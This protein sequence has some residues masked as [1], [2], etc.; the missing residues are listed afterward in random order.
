MK[1]KKEIGP[2]KWAERFL[3]WYC[4]QELLE[5][6]QGDLNEYFYRN[7]K[8]K[9][10]SKARFIYVMDV[11][12]FFR[13]YTIRKPNFINL[14]IHGMMMSSY[15]KTS[16]RSI[17]RNKLFSAINII[18]LAISMTVG[19]LMIGLLSD[20]KQYDTFHEHYDNIY[21]ITS[22]Y[23][24]LDH[25]DNSSYASTSLLAAKSI[26]ESIP[27]IDEVAILSRSGG[28]DGDV[29]AGDIMVPLSGFWA[30]G[31]FFKV[32]TFQ[33]VSGDI[34]NALKNPYSVV[35]T[36]MSAIKLFDTTEALGKTVILPNEKEFIVTGVIKDPPAFSHFKFDLLASLSTREITERENKDELAWDNMWNTY[37]YLLIP[38]ETDLQ[39][40]QSNLNVLSAGLDQT[41][42]NT[43]IKLALQP[44]SNIALGEDLNNSIGPVMESDNVWMIGI[45]SMIVIL[46][47][48]F[49][50]T[51][52]SIARSLKRSREVGIRKVVGAL[53]SHVAGQFVVESVII[54][55]LSLVFSFLLFVLV[56]P[57]FLNLSEQYYEM[58][59]LDLSPRVIMNFILLALAVGIIA[60]VFPALFFAR[61]NTIQ[62]LK[63]FSVVRGFRNLAI[64][65]SLIVIQFTISLMFI[66]AT[67]IGYKHYKNLLAF[68]LGFSTENILNIKL[69]RNKTDILLKELTELPEVKGLSTSSMITSV[70]NY[71]GTRMK[72]MDPLDS[73]F[74]HYNSIDEHYLPL[75]DHKLLAGKNFN[76][77]ADGAE[78]SEVIVNEKTLKRFNIANQDPA[79]AIGEIVTVNGKKMNIVGVVRDFY[80]G[81]SIDYEISE[82]LFRY[83]PEKAN[84]INVKIISK[85]W[86]TTFDKINSI[87]KKI[88][89]VHPLEATFYD[90]Q[91]ENSYRGFSSRIRVIGTLAFLAICIASIGLFGMVV[92]TTETRL[93]EISI[94]KVMGASEGSL[95]LLLSRGFLLML[96][97]AAIVAFPL[98]QFFFTKFVLEEYANNAPFAFYELSIG[99]CAVV[100]FAFLLISSQTLKVARANPAEV[101]KSE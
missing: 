34:S 79:K 25:E 35:L 24:Y 82:V 1:G 28:V 73:A 20:M 37:V 87:W 88:D 18:G 98:T 57:Y 77:R 86:P 11:L 64:R 3:S 48:C 16:S 29:K 66:A 84:Y 96:A 51:N 92:F 56:K 74:V 75:H 97:V 31:E 54:A 72:Y 101:L 89:N 65:K 38:N 4:K 71:W 99:L 36:E 30:N 68:D 59:L 15:L 6:L 93:K 52:L 33:M 100:G 55:L 14:L 42:K 5:D 40:L 43:S 13:L 41:V 81:K 27:G 12:K 76:P 61:V 70:G 44:L 67:I 80:Y 19:L 32:F 83:A 63:N 91:I 62:V 23:K 47:A 9:G 10:N 7:L 21:R 58:L 95:V 78:E 50:Y 53:K 49:N 8:L 17:V 22:K 90:E 39:N 85:D 94:R 45:L 46:S 60:G 69:S 2:P 26:Q